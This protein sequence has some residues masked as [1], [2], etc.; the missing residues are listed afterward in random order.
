[1]GGPLIALI[2]AIV[3]ISAV[4]GAIAQFLNK[5]NEMNAPPAG[6]PAGAGRPNGVP[7]RP[8]SAD[9]DMDRFLAEIDRLRRRNA[10]GANPSAAPPKPNRPGEDRS[11]PSATTPAGRPTPSSRPPERPA[12]RGNDRSRPRVIAELADPPL[13]PA[14]RG[15]A[16]GAMAAP[17]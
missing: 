15:V 4:V 9:K 11:R 7:A 5:L 8:P 13:P 17:P 3:I 2:I 12:D 6:R 16:R 1:M 10:E 14:R